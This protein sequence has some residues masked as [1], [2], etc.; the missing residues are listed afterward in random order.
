MRK[1]CCLFL[2]VLSVNVQAKSI[3]AFLKTI[4]SNHLLHM[5]YR[6]IPFICKPYGI[7]T[8]SELVY[9]TDV[10]SSCMGYLKEY[11]IVDP[12]EKFFAV[13]NLR[14]EQQYRVEGIGN[15][16]LLHHSSGHSY[17]EALLENG[18]ARIPPQ[19]RY[20]DTILRHRFKQAERR[21]KIKKAGIWSDVNVR[22]CFL[23]VNE[24]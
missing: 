23:M 19:L 4:E 21:A 11:R 7:E 9:R 2:F 22:N 8:L 17:S 3:A 24:K 5:N 12:N 18:Y 14:I 6:Q 16:C 10:N 1:I 13:Q 20:K 15:E